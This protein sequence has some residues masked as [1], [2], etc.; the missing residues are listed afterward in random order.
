MAEI[1]CGY[2]AIVGRPNVGKSTLLNR[3][4]GQKI[5]ITSRRPQT[6]RHRILGIKTTDASQVI[7]LDTPGLSAGGK[8]A[9]SRYMR[10]AAGNAI[11]EADVLLFIVEA[12]RWTEQDQHI[13]DRLATRDVQA[14]GTQTLLVINK[15]DNVADK[16][17]LLPY[18][19]ELSA[20][21]AFTDI[22]PISAQ[23]GD[24]VLVL[25]DRVRSLLPCSEPFYPQDQVTDRSERFLAGELI[26]EKL[27]SE[28]GQELPYAL[29]VEIE[30]FSLQGD[31]IHIGAI[32]WV[33][34]DGQK[35]IVI[36][37]KGLR[38]KDIGQQARVEMEA[39][40]EHKVFLRLWV[41]VKEGW[42]DNERLLASFGYE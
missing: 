5:S 27:M 41:K 38:L 16:P 22:I 12:L 2:V 6:T 11:N 39:L 15:V 9:M 19:K 31:V 1:P 20:K 28:L 32:I 25:E 7:Y 36:G 24:N 34:R 26:R 8:H 10:Q 33:E 17:A 13:L 21:M 42:S 4:L 30:A 37:K 3:I 18:I 14:S 35:A 23:G 40:F 29:T